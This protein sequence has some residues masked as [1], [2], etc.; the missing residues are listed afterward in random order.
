MPDFIPGLRL[1]EMFYRG[2][3]RPILDVEFPGLVHSAALIGY[4]SDVLGYDTARST[5]HEWG[6]RVLLFLRD[7]EVDAY[8]DRLNQTFQRALPYTFHGFSTN[9]ERPSKD[10]ARSLKAIQDGPVNHKIEVYGLRGFFQWRLGL[11]PTVPMKVADWLVTPEQRLLEVTAG[12]VFHDGLNELQAIRTRLAYYPRD[13]WLFVLAAQWRRIGQL[14]AFVGRTG[15]VGD[16]RGS[17][18]IAATLVHDLMRLAFL[19][20]KAYAPYPKW[21]GTAFSRLQAAPTLG[22]YLDAALDATTWPERERHLTRADVY[23]AEMHNALGITP[24]LDPRVSPFWDRPFQVIHADRFV[25]A[26]DARIA[27]PEVRTLLDSFGGARI[28]SVDQISDST[29][30]LSYPPVY[31]GLR[32]LYESRSE[33]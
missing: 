18:L 28:G 1:S 20:E 22:P 19:M 26:I 13:V 33:A 27:D 9:F 11:D 29:D 14:E 24:P 7:D 17:R 8:R 15:E 23:L 12:A 5:D 2:A 30:V 6:P 31:A 3:V 21:F 10:V 16:D 4:G 25:A 32:S